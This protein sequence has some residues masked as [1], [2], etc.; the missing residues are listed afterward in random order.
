[1]N[2]NKHTVRELG[3]MGNLVVGSE[4]NETCN[5][6]KDKLWNTI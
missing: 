1:M 3:L 5:G 6:L 2:V 4:S